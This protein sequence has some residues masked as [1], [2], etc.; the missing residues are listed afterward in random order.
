[1]KIKSINFV[2]LNKLCR[3]YQ[4]TGNYGISL[5]YGNT[6]LKLARQLNF[7]KG[8]ANSYN[9]IGGVYY[10][11][12]NYNKAL[13]NFFTSLK[14]R[15]QIGDI[16]GIASCYNNIGIIYKNQGILF[17]ERGDSANAYLNYT[18]ALENYFTSLKIVQSTQNSS[19]KGNKSTLEEKKITAA[20][21]NGIGIV[22]T[23]QGN[24]DKAM[25]NHFASLKIREE[26]DDKQG[27]G[28][29]Y[30]NIGYIYHHQHHYNKALENYFAAMKI[31]EEIGDKQGTSRS[32][33][34]I[35]SVYTEKLNYAEARVWFQKAVQ[36]AKEIGAK[37]LLQDTYKGLSNVNEKMSNYHEAY[38]YYQLYSQIKDSLFGKESSKQMAE[39]QT[40]YETEKKEHL[41][42][43]LERNEIIKEISLNYQKK[44]K[45]ILWGS[46]ILFFCLLLFLFAVFIKKQ[47]LNKQLRISEIS[48]REID[49][50]KNKMFS[51]VSHDMKNAFS[52]LHSITNYFAD[53]FYEIPEEEKYKIV[54]K[55]RET[56]NNTYYLVDNLLAWTKA[57]LTGMKI[58]F[59]KCLLAEYVNYC[60]NALLVEAKDKK[61]TFNINVDKNIFVSADSNMLQSILRNLLSNAI[62]YSKESSIID[63]QSRKEIEWDYTELSVRDYGI[64][65]N[66]SDL[67]KLFKLGESTALGPSNK[68]GAGLGL[69]L[70][71]ELI[72]L[73]KGT[74]NVSSVL[75][76]GTV[77]TITLKIFNN[78]CN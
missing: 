74:I 76:N 70:T 26:I 32:Y 14:I 44:I 75:G 33:S 72:E 38:K 48:L 7:K 39:M 5:H 35:A 65:M 50:S 42:K 77:F 1:M 69:I 30:N 63:V 64:G 78:E 73:N 21:Y 25:E 47:K 3:E 58:I 13:G 6:A 15:E 68:K 54:K 28:S 17:K 67:L 29:S 18:K 59:K 4:N 61:I 24:Y 46:S 34:N 2:H 23:E 37:Q 8:I 52:M 16:I 22:Y 71:K 36:L 62:K 12:G 45:N 43:V 60:V 66:P 49:Y 51:I 53:S 11:Q 57:H 9:N 40:K 31:W 56:S 20:I 19:G 10:Y 55:L 41:I 27:I